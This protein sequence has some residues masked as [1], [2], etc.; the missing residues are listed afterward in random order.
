MVH[1]IIRGGG[2]LKTPLD[3]LTVKKPGP[4][5]L[6]QLKQQDVVKLLKFAQP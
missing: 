1:E 4:I 5:G 6:K 2:S 3:L